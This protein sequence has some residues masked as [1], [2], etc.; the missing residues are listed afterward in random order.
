MTRAKGAPRTTQ[1]KA[2]GKPNAAPK[3]H[4]GGPGSA[5]P[6]R[7]L[8]AANTSPGAVAAAKGTAQAPTNAN[9]GSAVKDLAAAQHRVA[10]SPPPVGAAQEV[11]KDQI[12]ASGG[13]LGAPIVPMADPTPLPPTGVGPAV[14]A[15]EAPAITTPSAPGGG[16]PPPPA[17]LDGPPNASFSSTLPLPQTLPPAPPDGPPNAAFSSTEPLPQTPPPAPPDHQVMHMDV[18][19]AEP[20][21]G[22]DP[23]DDADPETAAAAL[24]KGTAIVYDGLKNRTANGMSPQAIS[25]IVPADEAQTHDD[26]ILK[27]HGYTLKLG[28]SRILPDD[29]AKWLIGHPSYDIHKVKGA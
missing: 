11:P 5:H 20:A 7:T 3:T 29:H 14:L 15:G 23:D 13:N 22:S 4:D 25:V 16:N 28:E 18:I 8:G 1:G 6:G 27:G 2:P 21:F 24:G 9:P 10:G 17:P 26:L 19:A 12:K